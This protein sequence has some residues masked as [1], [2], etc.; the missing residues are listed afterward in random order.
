MQ[1]QDITALQELTQ[2]LSGLVL[3]AGCV[4]LV[5]PERKAKANILPSIKP[6]RKAQPKPRTTSNPSSEIREFSQ[7]PPRLRKQVLEY[8]RKWIDANFERAY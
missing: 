2:H 1:E 3:L 4:Y 8:A 7:M 5:A 6:E